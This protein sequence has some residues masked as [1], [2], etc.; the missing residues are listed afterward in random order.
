[1]PR[2]RIAPGSPPARTARDRPAFPATWRL[3]R[4]VSE[5]DLCM[6][7]PVPAY[8]GWHGG[9]SD[10]G[11]RPR[12]L[13]H[14]LRDRSRRPRGQRGAGGVHGHRLALHPRSLRHGPRRARVAAVTS[15]APATGW[16]P[17]TRTSR[18]SRRRS[19]PARPSRAGS[20]SA[21]SPS[22]RRRGC[23][24][25]S[26]RSW[27]G[28][29]AASTSGC[30]ASTASSRT[31]RT[32]TGPCGSSRLAASSRRCRA[33]HATTVGGRARSSASTAASRRRSWPSR[34]RT[35]RR[36]PVARDHAGEP[37]AAPDRQPAHGRACSGPRG[38]ARS[39]RRWHVTRSPPA[40][41]PPRTAVREPA[42]GV[43]RAGR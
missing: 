8:T 28:C 7:H 17:I 39:R 3:G 38:S 43:R 30:R 6:S 37:A 33:L 14:P 36:H 1:M 5:F 31:R 21:R 20:G 26:S 34:R 40:H 18:T 25:R 2:V 19:R 10:G 29:P 27:A 23:T 11:H 32:S 13:V 24:S 35:G 12:R 4:G 15:A 9:P 22:S 16:A 42:D 41:A